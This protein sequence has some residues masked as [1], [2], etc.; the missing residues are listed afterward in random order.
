MQMLMFIVPAILGTAIVLISMVLGND[1]LRRLVLS[2]LLLIWA[3]IRWPFEALFG[4]F[5][6]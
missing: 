6:R 1:E 3:L 4:L 2:I 5:R